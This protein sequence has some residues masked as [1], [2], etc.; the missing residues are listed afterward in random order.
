M[1][2]KNIIDTDKYKGLIVL[3]DIHAEFQRLVDATNYANEHDLFI[4]FIGDLIDGGHQ[5]RETLLHV[6]RILD[7]NAG[8]LTIGNH[9]DKHF[10][11]AK[12]NPVLRNTSYMDTL[13]DAGEEEL[14][15]SLV[16]EVMTHR[17]AGLY[18]YH[19][20]TIFAHAG[21][22]RGLWKLPEKLSR[23][24]RAMALFGEPTGEMDD[25][26]YPIR[27]YNWVETIPS[28]CHVVVGHDLEALGKTKSKPLHHVNKQGGN[29]YFTDTGCGKH[30]VP[31]HNLTGAMFFFISGNIEFLKFVSFKG[32]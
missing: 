2:L 32:P 23:A 24:E 29:V 31:D 21:V 3:S 19:G 13:A 1:N 26:G 15:K 9:D 16:T 17:N 18:H 30:Q 11:G 10:R 25:R 27:A 12:G 8:V 6:K 22:H 4:V 20:A 28:G 7:D 14:F 5:P